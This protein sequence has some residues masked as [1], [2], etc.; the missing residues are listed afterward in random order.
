MS[1]PTGSPSAPAHRRPLRVLYLSWRDRENPEAGGSETFVER[2]AHV[3]TQLGH[4]VTLFTSRFPGA[5]AETTHD[6]VKVVRRGNR[7]SCYAHGIAHI[8]RHRDDYDIVIDVQNGVP[9][10]SPL[11]AKAPV[12]NVVHH[13]H[14]D[15]WKVIFGR[16]LGRVGWFLESRIAPKVYRRSRYV[17]VSQ[18]TRSDLG[19]LGVAA[20]RVDLIYSGNDH[21]EDLASYADIPRTEHPS[22]CVLGRLV[23][24]KQVEAAIDIVADLSDRYPDL[25]LAV[26]GSGYWEAR[27]REHAAARGVGERVAF[28]GFVDEATKHRLLA[29]SWLMLMPSHKEGWGLTI[30]EAGLHATPAVAFAHAGGPSES[31]QHGRTGLL[32]R[33]VAEMTHQVEHLL[34]RTT[35][36]ERL[37]AGARTHARSFDWS[38]SGTLLSH[39]LGSVLGHVDRLPQPS[40]STLTLTPVEDLDGDGAAGEHDELD[41]LLPMVEAVL[42]TEQVDDVI[43]PALLQR[44]S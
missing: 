12:V 34:R 29:Q 9:F 25:Q 10:W 43:D 31:I 15:Q 20:D 7:F 39:T 21:P 44:S 19:R 13:V 18:A 33:D 6:A 8:A 4:E 2:T 16:A 37:G 32:A 35:L 40:A 23:P 30:V 27:L 36:R 41:A 28:H 26:V 38:V 5:Q 1:R 22:I 11:V 42:L 17:T 14:R 24:H 3:L